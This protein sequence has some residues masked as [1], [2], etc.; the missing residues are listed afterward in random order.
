M[1]ATAPIQ[2]QTPKGSSS[3]FHTQRDWTR[4][5]AQNTKRWQHFAATLDFSSLRLEPGFIDSIRTF[6][7]GEQ[8]EGRTLSALATDY[9]E[10]QGD[11]DYLLAMKQFIGEEQRHAYYMAEALRANGIE[12]MAKQWSDGLFRKVRKLCGWEMMISVLLTAEVIAIAYY[13]SLAQ[14][15]SDPQSK[16]LFERILQD[17]SVHLQFHGESLSR[18]RSPQ[19]AFHWSLYGSLRWGL[20]RLFLQAVAALVWAEH[21]HV[22]NCRFSSFLSFSKHCDRLLENLV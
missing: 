11:P 7:L 8:S 17:E 6:Q 22:L 9:A 10:Q 20:H 4:T 13:A 21:H 12:P 1:I 15:S 18:I 16:R 2:E 3:S 14:A 5:F 19:G